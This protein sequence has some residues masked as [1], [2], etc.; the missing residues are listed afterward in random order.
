MLNKGV[1]FSLG[2]KLGPWCSL[3]GVILED[4]LRKGGRNTA[5][6]CVNSPLWGSQKNSLFYIVR[7]L[8]IERGGRWAWLREGGGNKGP[9][10]LSRV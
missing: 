1:R 6:N 3:W 9:K 2:G 10:S 7:H 5:K 8:T 4:V